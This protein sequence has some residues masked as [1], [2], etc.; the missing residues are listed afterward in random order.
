MS[1]TEERGPIPGGQAGAGGGAGGDPSPLGVRAS[2]SGGMAGAEGAAALLASL[3]LSRALHGE[4][5]GQEAAQAAVEEDWDV[6]LEEEEEEEFE[7]EI[8]DQEEDEYQSE[9]GDET[10]EE[11]EEEEET[12]E[13]D[14]NGHE[15]AGVVAG[16]GPP[17][18]QFQS[19]FRDLAHCRVHH[20][21]YNDRVLVG[22]H[23]GRVMVRRRSR[24]P[25]DPAEDAAPPQ[26]QEDLGEA[27][28][29]E[30]RE[31]DSAADFKSGN[32]SHHL[33]MPKSV[34]FDTKE[35]SAHQYEN[36]EEEKEDGNEK[37]EEGPKV[38]TVSAEGSSGEY[39]W[40]A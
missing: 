33:V 16:H 37:A 31:L 14:E 28:P 38:G 34:S 20:S 24:R 35:E 15:G 2:P 25:S 1:A 19:L 3:G 29:P 18:A 17:T 39:S 27:E 7:L 5:G 6:E 10:E 12:E 8:E 30:G 26:E 36:A 4:D 11:V 32:V 22:P 21:H 40:K 13:E 9:E 23:A